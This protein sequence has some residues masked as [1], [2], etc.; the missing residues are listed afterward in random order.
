MTERAG[1]REKAGLASRLLARSAS[2]AGLVALRLRG[3]GRRR[4]GEALERRAAEETL[5]GLLEQSAVGIFIVRDG[6]FTHVNA[7][8]AGMVGWAVEELVGKM[9]PVDLAAEADRGAVRGL[10]LPAEEPE[11]RV[12]FRA[13]GR[14]GALL[15]L[16]VSV[17]SVEH[18][19]RPALVGVALDVTEQVRAQRQL[20]YLAFY[21]PLTDLPNRSLFY[22][23]LGQALAQARRA[24]ERFALVVLDLDGFKAVNDLHGHETGDALLSAV[25]R[26][27]RLCVRETDTV[28]RMGGDEFVLLLGSLRDPADASTVAAKVVAALAEP[29]DV[30]GRECRVGASVGICVGPD[31]GEDMETLLGRADTAMY[32]SKAAGKGRFTRAEPS[33]APA[34]PARMLHLDL[35][36]EMAVGVPVIDE[37]HAR[38][39]DLLNRVAAEMKRGEDRERVAALLDEFLAFTRHHFETE[40]RIMERFAYPALLEHAQEHSRLLA[41][42]VSI[43]AHV[44]GPSLVLTLRSLKDWLTSHIAHGDRELGEALRASG[45]ARGTGPADGPPA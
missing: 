36:P 45:P 2:V 26:R 5:R 15:D 21:D 35:G 44:D 25:G 34:G 12:R 10:A 9:G 20:A 7:R 17:R 32:E 8:F 14:D 31:D 6:R 37:Q 33:A 3:L 29:F 28:A 16:D 27:L 19:G 41:D 23:R 1:T 43:R 18:G 30:G 42:L 40:N 24:G 22:D 4:R 13:V 38:M 39:A 11:R